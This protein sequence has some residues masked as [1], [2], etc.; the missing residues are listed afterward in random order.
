[1][2]SLKLQ[3]Q[4]QQKAALT[5]ELLLSIRVLGMDAQELREY[6][7]R[8]CEE[9]PVFEREDPPLS[10]APVLVSPGAAGTDAGSGSS[11]RDDS[12]ASPLERAVFQESEGGTLSSFLSDQLERRQLP[13]PLLHLCRYL[14][15]LLDEDGY[16]REEDLESV[17]ALPIP[18]G[19]LEEAV[20][21]LQSLDPPGVAARDLQECLLLQ[22]DRQGDSNPLARAI[23]CGFLPAL[24]SRQYAAIA[25]ALQV[26]LEQVQAAQEIIRRLNPRP[27]AEFLSAPEAQYIQPDVFVAEQDGVLTVSL[28]TA[29]I[30]R[31]F[32]NDDYLQ[33]LHTTEDPETQL[34]LRHKINQA[35]WTIDCLERRRATL[36]QISR[37]IVTK[38]E[39]FF[40]GKST[41]L[42]PMTLQQ[43]G[44]LLGLHK[45]TVSRCV[46]GK[47]LQCRQGT[48]PLKYFFPR[49]ME[50]GQESGVS[51][52]AV[53]QA[54]LELVR[55]EDPAHPFSD[56]MLQ[57]ALSA[58]GMPVARRTVAK[59]RRELHILNVSQRKRDG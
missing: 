25:K 38:N 4:L 44:K 55:R 24:G 33:L 56:H 16:L 7:T 39:A 5:P 30:P 47:Y 28:N 32:L 1:M 41:K 6:L 8:L 9:N 3:P 21:C 27:C 31:V 53:K 10:P 20:R 18:A 17:R 57:Q 54:L 2:E 45:S 19:L 14:V 50:A 43:A 37:L 51:N 40:S 15:D 13:K 23:V 22:L 26:T 49:P 52:Q 12:R 48:Y 29:Y 34:Y 11:A 59:Y 36:E 58:A 35:K 42:L 46:K